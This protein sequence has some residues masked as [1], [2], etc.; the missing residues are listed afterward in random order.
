MYLSSRD[1]E[2]SVIGARGKGSRAFDAVL[3]SS[4]DR[5]DNKYIGNLSLME[6][7]R[8]FTFTAP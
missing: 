6:E 1:W 3:H 7:G 2:G 5:N 4:W 8:Q